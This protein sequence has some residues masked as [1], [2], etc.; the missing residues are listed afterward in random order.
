MVASQHHST[1]D[2]E[3]RGTASVVVLRGLDASGA[4]EANFPKAAS[5][6]LATTNL[7]Y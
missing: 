5:L 2:V 4:I 6:F 7:L 3:M 1:T